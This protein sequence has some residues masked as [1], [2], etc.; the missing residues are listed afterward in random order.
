MINHIS[1]AVHNT[2]KVAEVLAELWNGYALPFPV[3][4]DSYLVFADDGRGTGV[5]VA[6]IDPVLIPGAGYPPEENFS[7]ET[8]TGEHEAK[9]VKSE[10]APAFVAVHLNLNSPLNIEEVKAIATREGWRCFVANRENVFRVIE[11][12]AENR[13]MLEVMTP[14][15]TE[16]YVEMM[17]PQNWADFL[18]MPLPPKSVLAANLNLI[19]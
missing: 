19:G 3:A 16:R 7:I 2:K 10:F 15:M 6:P 11:L 17:K 1:I 8:P 9:F 13:F 5:E 4:P 12:W 18:Q 14:E